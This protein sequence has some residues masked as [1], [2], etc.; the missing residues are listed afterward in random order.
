M[1]GRRGILGLI[2]GAPAAAQAVANAPVETSAAAINVPEPDDDWSFVTEYTPF[3]RALHEARNLLEA[4]QDIRSHMARDLPPHISCNKSWS[5]S[6]KMHVYEKDYLSRPKL[7]EL[8][9]EELIALLA[10]RGIEVMS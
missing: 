10:K 2:L 7:W 3:E 5:N 1:I 9:D 4:K 6:F 8:D